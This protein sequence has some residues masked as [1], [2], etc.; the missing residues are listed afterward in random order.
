MVGDILGK[1]RVWQLFANVCVSH[2]HID[3]TEGYDFSLDVLY[4]W[5]VSHHKHWK[6]AD[7]GSI[8]NPFFFIE[9][10]SSFPA[11]CLHSH[12]W[13]DHGVGYH[14]KF[15]SLSTNCNLA[16]PVLIWTRRGTVFIFGSHIPCVKHFEVTL[17]SF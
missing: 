3:K 16:C 1:L 17:T 10:I 8:G 6:D 14:F 12:R 7:Y 2:F 5:S 9:Q 4:R 13:N 15:V 11:E